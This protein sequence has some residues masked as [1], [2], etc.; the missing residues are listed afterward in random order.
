MLDSDIG[1]WKS[2][3][4]EWNEIVNVYFETPFNKWP[5]VMT[6]ELQ[7]ICRQIGCVPMHMACRHK[8]TELLRT[9]QKHVGHS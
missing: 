5:K 2:N 3:T 8:S 7:E 9:W 6:S 4:P 1:K